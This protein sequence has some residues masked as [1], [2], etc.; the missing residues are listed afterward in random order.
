MRQEPF[1]SAPYVH[2]NNEPKYHAML[3]RAVE[4]AKRGHGGPKHVLWIRAEDSL[5]NPKEIGKTEEAIKKKLNR[6]LQYHDQKTSGIPGLLPLYVDMR[7]RAIEKLAKGKSITIL[8]HTPCRIVGWD[9]QP[10]DR[11]RSDGSERL[12]DRAPRC[13]YLHFE[14]ASWRVHQKL[15]PGFFP[16]KPVTREW[17]VD[18]ATWGQS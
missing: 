9:L 2:R 6:F 7:A 16:L 10:G 8:K 18:E 1:L 13:I 17:T 4:E 3:L 11:E 5:H 14:G 15:A 12:L